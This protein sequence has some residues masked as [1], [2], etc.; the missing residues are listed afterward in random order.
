MTVTSPHIWVVY[1]T[2]PE[3]IKMSPVARALTGDA[4]VT[5]V[6]TGQ[7]R[8]LVTPLFD[9]L[10]MTPDLAV[11]I[12]RNDQSLH[13]VGARCLLEIGDLIRKSPPD[14][15]LVQGD[16]ASVLFT[17]LASYFER[18]LVGHVE[19]GLRS[20]DKFS[21]FPEEIMRRLTAGIADL[22][23]APTPLAAQHLNAEGV[24]REAIF[25]TG[26]TVVDAVR[27]ATPLA[28]RYASDEVR[29]WADE[30]DRYV[31][32]TLHRRESFGGDLKTILS[33]IRTF[34]EAH[35]GIAFIYPVHPNPSVKGPVAALLE[36]ISNVSLVD[37]IGYFDMVYLLKRCVTVLT[38][39]GGIQEEAPAL[40]KRVLV[41]RKVTERPE[42]VALGTA[43]LVGADAAVIIQALEREIE[44]ESRPMGSD[45]PYGDGKAG[46]R[47]ADIVISTLTNRPRRTRDWTGGIVLEKAVAS[48]SGRKPGGSIFQTPRSP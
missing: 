8:E 7:H 32:V 44:G 1:G 42:G 28:E 34:A 38:D 18:I 46:E 5:R 6:F 12:M 9:A 21:P 43:Q 36:G 39:S 20:F 26:N 4:R 29:R 14:C 31:V 19:A 40:G 33:A 15:V 45:T 17:A 2:R 35:P 11:D 30:H 48:P 25:T 24:D 10:D 27:A 22:H 47:I 37:P 16:T 23:F 13:E 3:V 41:A